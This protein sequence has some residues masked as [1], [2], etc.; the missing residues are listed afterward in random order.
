MDD[1]T[2]SFSAEAWPGIAHLDYAP[3][4][5]GTILNQEQSRRASDV[6][7][8][9]NIHAHENTD[10]SWTGQPNAL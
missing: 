10:D 7:E 9:P 4:T 3:D 2:S 1:G 5:P 6:Y 8:Q